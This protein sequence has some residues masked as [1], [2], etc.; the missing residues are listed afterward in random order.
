MIDVEALTV[1]LEGEDPAGQNLEY[2]PRYLELDS[3]AA[4]VSDSLMGD[5]RI[6]GRGP[7]WKKLGESC[8]EL[9]TQTRD[10]RV[11]V[12]LVI[13][14][15][16]TGGGLAG[17][18]A[19]LKLPLFLVK[20]L[21]DSFYP[22][23][24]PEDGDDP[25]ERLN[26]LAMLSPQAGAVNDPVMF[27]PRFRETR[28]VPSLSYTLRDLLISLNEIEVSGDKTIDPKLLRAELMNVAA[29]EIEEQ[30][31]LVQ[32]AQALVTE[33]CAEMNGKMKGGYSLDMSSL[34]HE[35]DRLAAFYRS[36][37]DSLAPASPEGAAEGSDAAGQSA[38]SAPGEKV[39]LLSY[40]AA[41]RAEA[42]LLLKKGAEYFQT[43][44]PNSPIPHLI[45]RALRFSGMSF[46]ELL[47]DI[48]PDALSR[49]R[50]ILGIKPE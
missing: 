16:L 18:T 23:L 37:L 27:I 9:W 47:E 7:D 14:E 39:A 13:A 10:L 17:L 15:A 11:A 2:D 1:V 24:D 19:G 21:W 48:V 20:E 4:E 46:I 25:L 44:E 40:H 31:A 8:R 45:E 32:E 22:K 42:L 26:I 28:L 34:N 6:E 35:L 3:L 36:H 12:Y 43:Q 33:L 41:S 49:G 5:S 50:D 29:P 38:A 30:A